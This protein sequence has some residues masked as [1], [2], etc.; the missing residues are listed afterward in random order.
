M[1]KNEAFKRLKIV[2]IGGGTGLST[3]IKGLKKF[4]SNISA[5][6]TVTDDGGSSGRLRK[7]YDIIPP[8][9]LRNCL[10]ALAEE[11]NILSELFSYRFGGSGEIAGHSF[12]NLFLMAMSDICGGFEKG[13]TEVSKIL[14]SKGEVIPSTFSTVHLVAQDEHSNILRGETEI[15]SLKGSIRRL[16]I[17][18]NDVDSAPQALTAIN[19]ADLVILGPGSFYTSVVSNLLV[20]DITKVL[21]KSTAKKIFICNIMSQ[22]GETAGYRAEEYLYILKDYIG[23]NIIDY[24]F[25]NNGEI[26]PDL[27]K[28]YKSQNSYPVQFNDQG[29]IKFL[30]Q[31]KTI[32]ADFFGQE[33]SQDSLFARHDPEKLAKKI[34]EISI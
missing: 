10:V 5:I 24:I 30:P 4:N 18:P 34:V 26:S 6:V 25:I 9:D 23:E 2:L 27:L 3:I 12:G 29:G 8:G 14:A 15:S 33:H 7:E 28:K 1:K 19:N 32:I 22:P 16:E 21:K 17:E 11:D 31:T 13:I 20:P